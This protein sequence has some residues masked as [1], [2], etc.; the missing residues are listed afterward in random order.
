MHGIVMSPVVLYMD[1]RS[2]DDVAATKLSA[3]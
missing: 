3:C 2:A 1:V